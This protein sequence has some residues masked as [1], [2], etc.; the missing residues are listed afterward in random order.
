[1]LSTDAIIFLNIFGAWLVKLMN[2][3]EVQ[4]TDFMYNTV[5]D[6]LNLYVLILCRH[7]PWKSCSCD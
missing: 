5:I 7:S 3:E 6:V 4:T 2:M 1:M